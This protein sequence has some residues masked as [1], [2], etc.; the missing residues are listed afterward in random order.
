MANVPK[1]TNNGNGNGTE[2][3]N[4]WPDEHES[5][6]LFCRRA[7]A[8][9]KWHSWRW[10]ARLRT[11][12]K[13]GGRSEMKVVL[14]LH[15]VKF[16]KSC[17]LQCKQFTVNTWDHNLLPYVLAHYVGVNSF[18]PKMEQVNQVKSEY[19]ED[20][21]HHTVEIQA[22][23]A[24][25]WPPALRQ[26]FCIDAPANVENVDNFIK[27]C[28][29]MPTIETIFSKPKERMQFKFRPDDPNSVPLFSGR[30]AS[31]DLAVKVRRKKKPDGTYS[32]NF[33]T[34]GV[35]DTTFHF[36]DKICDLQ[37]LPTSRFNVVVIWIDECLT[38]LKY[39]L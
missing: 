38:W 9:E 10:R 33:A 8:R 5:T 15:G 21:V 36:D 27:C 13:H 29:G 7:E 19:L 32:Y 39:S 35:I 2:Y 11:V 4:C 26:M 6:E 37:L 23:D 14:C 30:K 12:G 16:T 1:E 31:T 34:F 18:A 24:E 28:G 25:C 22:D 3:R 20:I 17:R